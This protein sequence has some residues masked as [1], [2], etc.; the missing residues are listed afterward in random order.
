VE[1]ES[2][3]LTILIVDDDVDLCLLMRIMLRTKHKVYSTHTLQAA[4]LHLSKCTVQVL[5]LDN[6]LPDGKGIDFIPETLQL[7]PTIK[8]VMISGDSPQQIQSQAL[9]AGACH[10]ITKPFAL[11]T[12]DNLLKTIF[13]ES[14]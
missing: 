12:L 9:E 7:H 4:R 13:Q 10:F 1:N 11:S 2:N 5:L 14:A 8:I 3:S 6:S